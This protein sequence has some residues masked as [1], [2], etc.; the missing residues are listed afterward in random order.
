MMH[1]TTTQAP[2]PARLAELHDQA[3]RDA[4]A[5]AARRARRARRQHA[6]HRTSGLLTAL[7]RR[8]RHR[9]SAP[10]KPVVAP[11]ERYLPAQ[12]ARLGDGRYPRSRPAITP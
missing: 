6:T 7:I 11:R 5:R 2:G 1:S 3:R 10:G 12:A 4:L 8:V 9:G